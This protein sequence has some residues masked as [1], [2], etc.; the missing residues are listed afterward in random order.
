[1]FEGRPLKG[2]WPVSQVNGLLERLE[3]VGVG[4]VTSKLISSALLTAGASVDVGGGGGRSLNSW[5]F[6]NSFD[7][8]PLARKLTGG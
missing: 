5:L 6:M 4:V 3:M 7:G 1:M 8:L 2:K